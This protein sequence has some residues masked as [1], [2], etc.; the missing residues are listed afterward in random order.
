MFNSRQRSTVPPKRTSI[1]QQSKRVWI[2]PTEVWEPV[3]EVAR[4][5]VYT[6]SFEVDGRERLSFNT[7]DLGFNCRVSTEIAPDE[8]GIIAY[9][10]TCATLNTKGTVPI[11]YIFKSDRLKAMLKQEEAAEREQ[12]SV[13][14]DHDDGQIFGEYDE[15]DLP[16]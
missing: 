2:E 5:L 1:S 9:D 10:P 4:I 3:S 8:N 6:S 7:A 12:Q 15:D 14:V 13:E 16:Y 11:L